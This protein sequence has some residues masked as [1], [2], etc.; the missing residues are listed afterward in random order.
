MLEDTQK[1]IKID[2]SLHQDIISDLW[3]LQSDDISELVKALSKTQEQ[4]KNPKRERDNPFLHY[5][6]AD[7]ADVWD[8]CRKPLSANGLAVVQ[9]TVP[10]TMI[11]GLPDGTVVVVTTLFHTSGQWI[12]SILPIKPIKNDPQ[13]IGSAITYARRYSLSAIIG[14]ASESEDDDA[15]EAMGR[16]K[17]KERTKDAPKKKKQ[18]KDTESCTTK[19]IAFFHKLL[20]ELEMYGVDPQKRKE[21]IK[22]MWKVEHINDLTKEQMTMVLDELTGLRDRLKAGKASEEIDNKIEK[23]ESEEEVVISTDDEIDTEP[24][25]KGQLAALQALRE[26]V[27]EDRFKEEMEKLGVNSEN[28]LTHDSAGELIM[29]LQ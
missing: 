18:N 10:N 27:G 19:Q 1:N 14:I 25:S 22:A 3:R 21:N 12:R 4:I 13:A 29:R 8:S 20:K 7:L 23:V 2:N 24:P 16:E 6:Y 15:E 26:R 11:P 17:A 28:E 5:K 9:T